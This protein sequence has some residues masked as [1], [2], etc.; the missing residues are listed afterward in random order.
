MRLSLTECVWMALFVFL[1]ICVL[2]LMFIGRYS[3]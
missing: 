2:V 3:G 1:L